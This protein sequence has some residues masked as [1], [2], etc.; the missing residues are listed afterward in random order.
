M[1]K[2]NVH[3]YG[4]N[5]DTVVMLPGAYLGVSTSDTVELAKHAMEGIDPEFT[6]KVKDSPVLVGGKNFGCGSSR[7]QAPVALKAAGVAA[8]LAESF[9][10][11]FFRNAIN[12][13]LPILVCPD[14]SAKVN[15]GDTLGI[16]L[17]TGQ[18]TNVTSGEIL[19]GEKLP[20]F[21]ME[22]LESGGLIPRREEE[23]R[24]TGK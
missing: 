19:N 16:N 13:G 22:I 5:V 12:I 9:G 11:I 17:T 18:V 4:D 23:L 8:I 20:G 15:E 2:G 7:E 3:K 1:I 14:I 6:R 10:R 24:A 21:I